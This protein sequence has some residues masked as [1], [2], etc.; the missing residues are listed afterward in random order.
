V[1][2]GRF[3]GP[4]TATHTQPPS[5]LDG[6]LDGSRARAMRQRRREEATTTPTR[7][8]PPTRTSPHRLGPLL[9]HSTS[10]APRTP[11]NSAYH[12]LLLPTTP[13]LQHPPPWAEKNT[14]PKLSL[15]GEPSARALSSL[16]GSEVSSEIL[17]VAIC[18]EDAPLSSFRRERD[19]ST[20]A[21]ELASLLGSIALGERAR[22]ASIVVIPPRSRLCG[23]NMQPRDLCV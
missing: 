13:N 20:D 7:P 1:A 22:V 6:S 17:C 15:H 5:W 4:H 19:I 10:E 12:A 21:R 11:R 9:L 3:E 23:A 18:V 16:S 8:T 2:W 14:K